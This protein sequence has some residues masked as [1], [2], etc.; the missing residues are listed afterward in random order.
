[1]MKFSKP[2]TALAALIAGGMAAPAFAQDLCGGAGANGQWIGGSED[3]SDVA[4]A[5]S[6]MEQMALVLMGNEYVALFNVS[7]PTEVRMEAQGR[8]PGD[9]LFDLRDETGTIIL[10]DDDSGGDSAARAETTLEP[11]TYCLSM[12]SYDG[13]PM[14][15]FVRVGRLEQ[16]ALT[17]GLMNQPIDMGDGIGDG[18][19]GDGGMPM[20]NGQMPGGICDM[21]QVTNYFGDGGA[22]DDSLA[23]GV[24]V[25]AP[26][27]QV[28]YWGFSL[29]G[30]QPVT[31]TAA[32]E[33]ADP[34]IT[35]YDAAGNWL[36]ENDDYDGLNSQID[37]QMPLAAG[38][39]CVAVSALSDESA[40]IT[41]TLT[42]FD[43]MAEQFSMYDYAEAAP[44]LDG[45]YPVTQ[46]G[47]LETRLRQDLQNAGTAAWYSFE[48]NEAGLVL[49]EAVTNGIGDPVLTL[50]DDFGRLIEMND[51][52]GDNYD[53]LVAARVQ[54]GT[55]LVAVRQYDDS[56]PVLT[57]LLIERFVAA[58]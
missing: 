19:M 53:P 34:V 15:G 55:Y 46:L 51:D 29:S 8:G 2:A 22:V 41:L 32:N 23:G 7:A 33:M 4:T 25:E 54:P 1:M 40:P 37:M 48:V 26:V 12:S 36:A 57:R 30:S 39:Y 6:Y 9:P 45:S 14:T 50:Y 52:Y 20:G 21:A 17:P 44:P 31:I 3:A 10:S 13:S 11:G 42:G 38:D 28:A 47:T 24:T 43:P 16:E 35:L 58:R 49:I 5:D 56:T 18:T 27:N